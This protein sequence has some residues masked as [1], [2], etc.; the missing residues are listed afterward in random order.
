MKVSIYFDSRKKIVRGENKGRC[1]VKILVE[2]DGEQRTRRY[3]QTEVFAT[4]E[5]FKMIIAGKYGRTSVSEAELL[6]KKR[7]ALLSLE[8]KA[9]DEAR[10]GIHPDDFEPR[11]RSAGSND[12]P[13]DM[14]LKYSEE[15]KRDGQVGTSIF[16]RSAYS[17]FSKFCNGRLSFIQVTPRWL[18][19]Y[20]KWLMD[21]GR[22]ISTVGTHVRPMR[23]VFKKA[24][25]LGLIPPGMY[26]FGRN[27]Y[28]CPASK[29]RKIALDEAGKNIILGYDGE[30]YK[31]DI[32]MWKFS[33]FCNGMNFADIAR[34]K[35][36]NIVGDVLTFDRTKTKNTERNKAP[37]VITMHKEALRIIAKWGGTDISPNAYVFQV[38]REGLTA[39]QEK[40]IIADW[41][42]ETNERLELACIKINEKLTKDKVMKADDK[43]MQIPKI[44]TYWAR[45][46]FA[47]ILYRKGASLE[48]IQEALG[49][50]DPKTTKIYLDGFD[51][52]TKRQMSNL[53]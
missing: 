40:Y 16:Y 35:R 5:E 13:L 36:W 34:L 48:F 12:N 19:A 14:L 31:K 49:H 29:G 53:L 46:T 52:D 39:T 8:R 24:I 22:S 45:H 28:K 11:F 4:K 41:L 18:M 10:P 32:D 30:E 2:F 50:A 7:V 38:L 23:T 47:T 21:Q 25:D 42:K 20:E 26:P 37:I 9:K 17:S 15:L 51:L 1:H 33:Y 44:T 27:K 6:E 43:P 3:Y